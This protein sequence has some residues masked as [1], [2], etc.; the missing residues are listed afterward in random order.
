MKG[1]RDGKESIDLGEERWKEGYRR[2][3][4]VERRV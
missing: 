3:G 4:G 1:R 2:E